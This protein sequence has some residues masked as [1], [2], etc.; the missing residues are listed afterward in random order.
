MGSVPNEIVK[1]SQL[2]ANALPPPESATD[3]SLGMG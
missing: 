2:E 1:M 3:E